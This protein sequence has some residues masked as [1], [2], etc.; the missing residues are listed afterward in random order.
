MVRNFAS[1]ASLI[2]GITMVM[3]ATGLLQV[4]LPIRASME[5]LGDAVVGAMGSAYY[6]G[7]TIGCIA[8]PYLVL[9]AGHI[10]TYAAIASVAS[11]AALLHPVFVDPISWILLRASSGFCMSVIYL[12]I[13]SWLNDKATNENRGVVMSIYIMTVYIAMTAGQLL[14]AIGPVEGFILFALTSV[15]VSFAVLPVAFTRS[16]QPAAI[17]IVR[18]QPRALFKASPVGL[19]GT[20]VSGLVT[21]AFFS[22]GTVFALQR[23]FSVAE[24]ATFMSASV[25]G[26]AVFQWPIGKMSDL[27]DRRRVLVG[28][29]LIA[30]AFALVLALMPLTF[31]L[32]V[33]ASFVYG[34][35]ALTIYSVTA[36]HCFDMVAPEDYV[37]AAATIL[38]ANGVGAAIGP[39][40]AWIALAGLG[41]GGLFGFIA[42]MFLALAGFV[43]WRMVQRPG[44]P[45]EAD[46]SDFDL[47]STAPV[48]TA[49]TPEP[50]EEEDPN[51]FV[52]EPYVDPEQESEEQASAEPA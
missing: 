46:R 18:F 13:E 21:G 15:I 25:A 1:I 38:L 31:E 36:A 22:F 43:I 2:I 30:A 48:G 7:F 28:A 34:G 33:A 47:Y 14:V 11:A 35:C 37:E 42:A 8:G 23:G 49:I 16:A 12:V 29:V 45:E 27:I 20:A 9:T 39:G 4:L 19:I 3:F 32:L 24:A 17:A 41:A 50:L 6:V 26:G 40:F 52:P 51:V 44:V 10:R 5:N